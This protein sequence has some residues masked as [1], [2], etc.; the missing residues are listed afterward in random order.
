MGEMRDGHVFT[1]LLAMRV[2]ASSKE[3]ESFK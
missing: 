1:S 3:R 2:L